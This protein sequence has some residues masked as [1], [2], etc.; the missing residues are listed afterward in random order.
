MAYLKS[1]FPDPRTLEYVLDWIAF[2]FVADATIN[3][4][5]HLLTGTGKN[6]K[7]FLMLMLRRAHGQRASYLKTSFYTEKTG[8]MGRASEELYNTINCSFVFSEEFSEGDVL[9]DDQMKAA[10]GGVTEMEARPMYKPL[11]RFT[12]K[13]SMVV[14]TNHRPKVV[15]TDDGIWRRVR[16]LECIMYYTDD[17][18]P[19]NPHQAKSRSAE[20]MAALLDDIYTVAASVSFARLKARA[21]AQV[22]KGEMGFGKLEPCP[23]VVRAT[24]AYRMEQ[25]LVAAFLDDKTKSVACATVVPQAEVVSVFQNWCATEL[26]DPGA[27]KRKHNEMMQRMGKR[28]SKSAPNVKPK[29]W[30]NLRILY[31]D[32]EE[33]QQQHQ[34]GEEASAA[35]S[36][37]RQRASAFGDEEDEED[38]EPARR[39][40]RLEKVLDDLPEEEEEE[41][42]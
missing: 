15:G 2:G 28:Y 3:Q 17:P 39:R 18:D 10:V 24:A 14:A 26:G 19:R 41:D 16:D 42:M 4:C 20:Q 37:R 21:A 9:Y 25:D 27:A 31:D 38:V 13:A 36:N 5:M 30:F 12:P 23:A 7:S 33:Q 1:M 29:G 8:G 40:A 35:T 22:A 6:G 32:G 11:R 34:N